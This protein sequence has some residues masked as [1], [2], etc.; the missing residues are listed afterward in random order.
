MLLSDV[1]IARFA[2]TSG[3][4]QHQLLSFVLPQLEIL[5]DTTISSDVSTSHSKNGKPLIAQVPLP[6]AGV[7]METVA[8]SSP[9]QVLE[10]DST[11]DENGSGES[12]ERKRAV[13]LVK[14][15]SSAHHQSLTAHA[16]RMLR[17]TCTMY[18][19]ML[20]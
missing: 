13:R 14:T 1:H 9:Q 7:S 15:G 19:H 5:K 20:Q 16:Q 8:A 18:V 17:L 3:P 2:P 6:L 4:S 10:A 11:S 12:E